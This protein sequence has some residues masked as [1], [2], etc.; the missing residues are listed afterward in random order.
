MSGAQDRSTVVPDILY[1]RRGEGERRATYF[2][3]FFDLVYVFAVTQLSHHLLADLTW[4]GAAQTAFLLLAVYWAWNYTTWMANWFDPEVTAVRL[5]LAFVMLASLL[6]AVA[7][8]EAFG[9]HGLL[10][11]ASYC[12]LQLVRNAFVGGRH[13]ARPLQPQLPP[14]PGLERAARSLLG[15]RRAGR[16]R[17]PLGL[18]AGRPGDRPGRARWRATGCRGWGG[19]PWC[20]G[21]SPPATS[22]SGSSC[23]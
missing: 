8:P 21:R 15:R 5:V 2:E 20:S 18:V 3:L 12:A 16:G 14:D 22:P 17:R 13:A 19:R 9:D 6:M 7:I 4:S 23:S 10:L 1:V 11:A